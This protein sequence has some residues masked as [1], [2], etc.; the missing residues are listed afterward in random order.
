M[1]GKISVLIIDDHPVFR[2]GLKTIIRKNEKFEIVAEAGNARDAK[3]LAEDLRPDLVLMDIS[4]PDENGIRLSKE[5]KNI[6]EQIQIL[7][8]SMHSKIE[9]IAEAFKNGATGF[10]VKESA[11]E[12]LLQGMEMVA[13][14]KFFLDSSVSSKVIQKLIESPDRETKITDAAYNA[15]TPREQE[16]LRMLAEGSSAKQC[17]DKLFISSKTVENHRTNIMNKLDL[18]STIELVR[19]AAKLGLIDVDLWK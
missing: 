15:L 11:S 8:V 4:L 17:A 3:K 12:N 19:Y 13:D 6:S 7:V 5:I 16:I 10:I 14:G 1:S 18:H 9:Y 2:E